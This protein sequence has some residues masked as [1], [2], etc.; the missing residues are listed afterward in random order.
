MAIVTTHVAAV[1]ELYVAYFGRPADVAGLDYWTNVVAAEG[2]KLTAVSAAF[3]KEKEYTDLF[4]GKTN[5]QIIDMIYTNM[6]GHA[7]DAAGR[8]YWVDL[9]TAGTVSV[10][11]IVAE[12][13]KGAQGSDDTAVNNK[14]VGAT[15][16]TAALDTSAEQAGYSG[17]AAAVLAKAFVAGITT[18]ATL[19]AAIA[20]TS[21]AATVSAVVVAGTPFTVVGALQNLD[22]ATKAEA[23]FLVTA[24]GDTLATTSATEASLDLAVSTASTAVGNALPTDA[25]A[26]YS[27]AGT[28]TAVKAALVADQQTAN[29][30]ALKTAS[31]NVTAANANIAK[32]AG[33]T[34]AVTTLTGA[35]ASAEATL[36]AQGA[37]EAK[38]AADLAFYNTTKGGAAV[39]VAAD[40]SVTGLISLVDGKLTLATGVTEAKNPGVTALLNSSVALEAAQAANTSANTVVS[41]SQASV[42]FL[43]T[44]PAEVTS[45]QNLAKLMTDFTFATGVL[46][47]EAQVNQQL[48]LLQA[49]DTTGSSLFED[50]QAAVTTH[51]GLA[52]DSNPLT[53]S[54]TDAT[55]GATGSVKA[56]NDS[57]KALNDA[58]AGLQKAEANVTQ[59]D[60]LHAAVTASSKVFTDNGY[61]LQQVDTASEIGSAASDIFVVGKTV[62]A[63]GTAS[64]ISLFGLQGTDSLYV[65]SGYTL[66]TG[67]LTT[68]NNAALEVFV[69]QVGGDTVLK[70][71]TSVFGSSTATP[72]IITITLVGV[73]AA[74]IVMNN[75]IITA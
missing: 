75:G 10:D 49:R 59:Y 38:L 22:V 70:M 15:A 12:V 50:F 60:A 17:A 47:T 62:G 58:V 53:A 35:K 72:E 41:L 51:K 34:A 18:N 68:G 45:L 71:E 6:F 64:T 1:Q 43:D 29:A 32:V 25:K 24:D 65:G 67:A 63:A 33:L 36:K 69:S 46:P 48:Q 30:A 37:A 31:D 13:A 61:A 73:D 26:I 5:A 27:A 8:T 56:A 66:N 39:T 20:P 42:D 55:T 28:S 40:G 54:L 4:A 23:A 19:D 14:V 7:A 16:F 3:A 44:T 57:I 74:D 52:D 21:L 2:G 11:M 9:L